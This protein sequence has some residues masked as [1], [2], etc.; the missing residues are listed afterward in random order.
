M[1]VLSA[2]AQFVQFI[3]EHNMSFRSGDHFTKL[4]K[5]MF[6]DSDIAKQFHCSRTKTMVLVRMGNSKFCQDELLST[7]TGNHSM[8]SPVSYSLLIDESN[9]RGVFFFYNNLS[10]VTTVYMNSQKANTSM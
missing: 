3:A 2:E 1:Q 6:P 7:L 8:F 10:F 4:V 5:S 9:D